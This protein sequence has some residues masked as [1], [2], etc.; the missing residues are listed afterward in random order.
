MLIPWPQ[1]EISGSAAAETCDEEAC[2]RTSE[3]EEGHETAECDEMSHKG[4][5]V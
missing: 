5:D 2:D 1:A 3:C 4:E